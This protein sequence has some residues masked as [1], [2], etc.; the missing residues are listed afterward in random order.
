MKKFFTYLKSETQK[1]II[2]L[3]ADWLMS[4]S[5]TPDKSV[6]DGDMHGGT[7][8]LSI[9]DIAAQTHLTMQVH[10]L[11]SEN[12][13]E[14]AIFFHRYLRMFS[15]LSSHMIYANGFSSRSKEMDLYE[16]VVKHYCSV[17]SKCQVRQP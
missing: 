10:M 7:D 11:H 5:A 4:I 8:T 14:N 17:L 1:K 13:D 15:D 16:N 2:K 3:V 9:H 6:T 12:T